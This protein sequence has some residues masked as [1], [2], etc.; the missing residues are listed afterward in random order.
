MSQ[1]Q[2]KTAERFTCVFSR[3]NSEVYAVP[4]GDGRRMSGYAALYDRYSEDLGGFRT[5]IA[6]GAFDKAV[7]SA[8]CRLLVNHDPNLIMGRTRAGTLRLSADAKGLQFEGDLPD[9]PMAAHYLEAVRRGDMDG[10]SF[11]CTVDVYQWDLDSEPPVR[12][13]IE[14]GELY[15]VGP[16]TFPAFP[17]TSV[18]ASFALEAARRER[19]GRV[20]AE[21][22]RARRARAMF[23]MVSLG[24]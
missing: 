23:L 11:T 24:P 20:E 3:P 12:T 2:G 21:A 6:P 22:R 4:E 16:V 19:S 5:K 13:L 14:I 10:C 1:I 8:D 18:Q 9:T 7:I 15:D 17:D